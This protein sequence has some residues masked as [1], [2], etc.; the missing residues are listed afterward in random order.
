MKNYFVVIHI[1]LDVLKFS[2]M[3]NR[4]QHGISG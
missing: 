2:I 4:K 1:V 3:T